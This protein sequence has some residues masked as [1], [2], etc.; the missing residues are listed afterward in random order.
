MAPQQQM[1][2]MAAVI[3]AAILW[4]STGTLQTLMPDEKSPLV[5]AA[6]RLVLGAASLWVVAALFPGKLTS[7]ARTPA[8]VILAAGVAIGLYN[9]L[10]FAGV[11]RAGV[12]VGTAI[13]IGSAPIWVAVYE[14]ARYRRLPR[15]RYAFAQL[16]AIA[17]AFVLLSS[18]RQEGGEGAMMGVALAAGAGLCYAAYSLFTSRAAALVPSARLAALTF[19]VAAICV[20]PVF[21]FAPLAWMAMPAAWLPLLALGVAATGVSYAFYT[22]GLNHVPA[23]TAVTLALAEPLTAWVLATSVV[24]E[25]VS[26]LKLLGAAL[27][28]SGLALV[29]A[30]SMRR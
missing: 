11:Q 18:G 2:G 13:A 4:G 22:W 19:T 14:T 20:A 1:A 24:G 16:L 8:L 3:V 25:P 28:L 29:S 5:V 7:E 10:F 30:V 23:S 9:L 12:G 21:L 17:G 15:G 6:M 27:L 26:F